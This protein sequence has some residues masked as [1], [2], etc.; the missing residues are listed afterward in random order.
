MMKDVS[1]LI[2][3]SRDQKTIREFKISRERVFTYLAIILIIF[4][5]STKFGIDL[6]VDLSNNSRIKN[7]EHT[8]AALQ[9]RLSDIQEKIKGISGQMQAIASK[10]DELRSLLG[11]NKIS[12]DLRQ[13]G[14]GGAKEY[15][16]GDDVSGMDDK[17]LLGEQLKSLSQLEREIKLELIS[18]QDMIFVF[19]R[20]QDS[21]AYLPALKPVIHGMTSSG[22]GRRYHPVFKIWRHHDGVD[23]NAPKGTPIYASADGDV[24]FSG[25]N[26]GLGKMVMI[27]HKY[28]FTTGYGHMDRIL[29][30]AGQKIKR[31]EKIGEVGNTGITT[32]THLH[33]EVK[34]RGRSL[35]PSLYYFEDNGLNE[36]VIKN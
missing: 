7:L 30:R 9:A 16:A 22:F 8:N 31:G 18:Y 20:K 10:D 32:G 1:R 2:F 21:L 11:I 36:Q 23:I 25:V 19:N 29:V 27:N 6:L 15:T 35:D 13:V 34:F 14:I 33:Y 26:G 4:F 12:D 3:I 28:G 24:S 5:L 17:A